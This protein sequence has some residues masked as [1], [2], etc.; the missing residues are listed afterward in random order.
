[1]KKLSYTTE[2]VLE[3]HE[4]GKLDINP[5]KPI[6]S[7][8]TLALAYTP[9]VAIPCLEI[10]KNPLLAYKYTTKSL[11]NKIEFLFVLKSNC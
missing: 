11:Q 2:E 3:F 10:Q 1:M 7:M 8:K 6:D 4:G 5:S 9:G